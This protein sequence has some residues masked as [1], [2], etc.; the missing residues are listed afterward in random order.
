[1]DRMT[2][3][4]PTYA[5]KNCPREK[6]IDDLLTDILLENEIDEITFKQWISSDS[7][8]H[9]IKKNIENN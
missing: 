9:F 4:N 1:M 7:E 5:C 3:A 8:C 6:V 2:C